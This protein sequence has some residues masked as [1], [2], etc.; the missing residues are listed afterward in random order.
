MGGQSDTANTIQRNFP[1]PESALCL[2]GECANSAATPITAPRAASLAAQA[3]Q[4]VCQGA[5]YTHAIPYDLNGD[6][7]SDLLWMND[8]THQFGWWLLGSPYT[9]SGTQYIPRTIGGTVSV[10]PG[11][12]IAA[13]GDLNGDLKTDLIWTSNNRDLYLWTSTGTAFSSKYVGTYPEGWKLVGAAD[14]D[15][16]GIDDLIWENDEACE[17]GY[18]LMNGSTVKS[19]KAMSVTC[20][21]Q[22]KFIETAFN[23]PNGTTPA[24]YWTNV[25]NPNYPINGVYRWLPQQQTLNATFLGYQPSGYSFVGGIHQSVPVLVFSDPNNFLFAGEDSPSFGPYGLFGVNSLTGY[26]VVASGNYS[27]HIGNVDLLWTDANNDLMVTSE[28]L[29]VSRL[30]TAEYRTYNLG[31]YPAGWHVVRPGVQN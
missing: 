25:S 19:T 13:T 2:A 5:T 7:V 14:I 21:F 20:G 6:C 26:R 4:I 30:T 11:Y 15:G 31:T 28:W 18:W 16:D 27:S 23:S 1:V 24:I 12:W 10:T 22:I 8:Q 3:P 17:Y 9:Q 29:D